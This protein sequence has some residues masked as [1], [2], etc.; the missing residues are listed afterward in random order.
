MKIALV[1]APVGWT[2]QPPVDLTQIAGSARQYG[3]DVFV[4]DVNARLRWKPSLKMYLLWT[5]P[6]FP[7]WSDPAF[8]DAFFRE[9][10]GAIGEQIAALLRTEP[11]VVYFSATAANLLASLRL[12]RLVKAAAPGALIVFGGPHFELGRF[13]LHQFITREKDVDVVIQGPGEFLFA[14]LLRDLT[15]S[16]RPNLQPGLHHRRDGKVVIGDPLKEIGDVDALPF[17]DFSRFTMF[18]AD[19]ESLPLRISRG[20]SFRCPACGAAEDALPVR[21]MSGDRVFAEAMYLKRVFPLRPRLVFVD[22]VEQAGYRTLTRFSELI[23]ENERFAGAALFRWEARV[24]PSP[25]LSEA[26]LAAWAR[27][28]CGLL[29]LSHPAA[30]A[31]GEALI[32]RILADCRR[33]GIPARVEFSFARPE[34]SEEDMKRQIDFLEAHA[35]D[36]TAGACARLALFNAEELDRVA[37]HQSERAM[38]SPQAEPCAP[39]LWKGFLAAP[40]SM[41]VPA[42]VHWEGFRAAAQKAGVPLV[43]GEH[44]SMETDA[45]LLRNQAWRRLGRPLRYLESLDAF[46]RREPAESECY[47][48][49]VEENVPVLA[50]AR[51]MLRALRLAREARRT[52]A[53]AY[54][55]LD[56]NPSD[57]DLSPRFRRL[58]REGSRREILDVVRA[59][60]KDPQNR[61]ETILRRLLAVRMQLAQVKYLGKAV[62]EAEARGNRLEIVWGEEPCDALYLETLCRSLLERLERYDLAGARGRFGREYETRVT[63]ARAALEGIERP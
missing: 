30:S 34:Q 11:E 38:V 28:N 45:A 23:A 61:V 4:F 1:H 49:V 27:G 5:W 31:E 19:R 41:L 48:R 25:A 43:N 55:N 6:Q 10:S 59:M 37:Q 57:W 3:H 26:T 8:V 16:G 60:E 46:L 2:D 14:K 9:E 22:L 51:R 62:L 29:T 32:A 21:W 17:A 13:R 7:R 33:L 56:W 18:Y 58:A 12:A 35:R 39:G 44:E 54:N 53:E 47:Y 63:E 20:L 24:E 50:D 52:V 40:G 36:L 42:L 15:V